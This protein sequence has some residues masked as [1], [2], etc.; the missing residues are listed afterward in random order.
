MQK[1]AE[2]AVLLLFMVGLIS[3]YVLV[4]QNKVPS[5]F[6]LHPAEKQLADSINS[7]R[8]R[9]G[10]KALPLSVSLSFVARA[11]VADLFYNHPDTSICNL[12]SW[13]NKGPWKACCYN[14]Y[15]VNHDGMWKKPQELTNY[16]YRGYEMVAY[17]QDN[18]VV[19]S[20]LSLWKDSPEAMA[21]ILTNGVWQKKSWACMGVG[22]NKHYASVWFGQR[23][24][25]AGKPKMCRSASK[26]TEKVP[27]GNTFYLIYGS[28]PTASSATR[29][30]NHVKARGFR[31]PGILRNNK[32]IR[33]YLYHTTNFQKIKN[34]RQKLKKKYPQLWILQK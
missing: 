1:R 27:A 12:S 32:H 25:K 31:N 21:M 6:C 10:K 22:L 14:P 17:T 2:W 8:V 19:D 5:S 24:D 30:M 4:A 11:H 28:Y 29:A 13:S 16:R 7:I 33:V 9:N 23:P 18:L 20:V 26:S 15:V 34:V 3:P